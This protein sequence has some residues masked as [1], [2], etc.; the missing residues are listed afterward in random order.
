MKIFSLAVLI[1]FLLPQDKKNFQQ[2]MALEGRWQRQGV[3]APGFEEWKKAD[4]QQLSGRSYLLKG[5]DTV[6][7]ETVK[8]SRRN[9]QIV[10]VATA[11]NQNDNK[12]TAFFL[13]SAE[14]KIFV[15]ENNDHDFPK[16]VIY[17]L[18][19]ADSLHAWIDGGALAPEKR[20]DYYF[21][22]VK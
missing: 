19:S 17:H 22:K 11:A 1:S 16:R 15:F 13:V 20:V 5:E 21:R 7:T 14:K 2:L 6:V 3:E 18:V 10:Y 12:P 8:L 9:G 4:D